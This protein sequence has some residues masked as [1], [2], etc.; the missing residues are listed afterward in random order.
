M[1]RK[2]AYEVAEKTDLQ[3]PFNKR[4]EMAGPNWLR[5]LLDRHPNISIR[6]PQG[7]SLSRAQGFTDEKVKVFFGVYKNLLAEKEIVPSRIWNMDET[8][9]SV[10][11]K[12]GKIIATKG[13]KQNYW[14]RKGENYY[15]HM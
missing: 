8:G 10:A 15:N 5:G 13:A 4:T 14:W 9:I 6:E 12:P 11:H 1:S 7:T 3:H 2:Q